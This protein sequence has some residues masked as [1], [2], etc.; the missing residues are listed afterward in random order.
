MSNLVLASL[1]EHFIGQALHH[2]VHANEIVIVTLDFL[3]TRCASSVGNSMHECVCWERIRKCFAE[4]EFVGSNEAEWS[5]WCPLSS[6]IDNRKSLDDV[7]GVINGLALLWI[8]LRRRDE[9]GW[10]K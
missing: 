3:G 10:A 8:N 7:V 6:S 9:A 2:D 1:N 5:H 4:V